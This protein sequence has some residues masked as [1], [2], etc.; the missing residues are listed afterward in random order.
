MQNAHI[1][2]KTSKRMIVHRSPKVFLVG[3]ER[4]HGE[5]PQTNSSAWERLMNAL[6]SDSISMRICRSVA[7][8]PAPQQNDCGPLKLASRQ[9]HILVFFG[10]CKAASIGQSSQAHVFHATASHSAGDSRMAAASPSSSSNASRSSF[11]GAAPDGSRTGLERYPNR[12]HSWWTK[13]GK[14]KG[15]SS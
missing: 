3:L 2:R 9:T 6:T 4:E 12:R 13:K 15:V 8:A 14:T 10:L 11:D 5:N 7:L 1:G